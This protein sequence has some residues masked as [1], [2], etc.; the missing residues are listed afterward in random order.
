MFRRV[1]LRRGAR[2]PTAVAPR[3]VSS[4]TLLTGLLKCACCGASMT[5]A[6]GKGGRY[7]YYKCNTRIG[8]GIDYCESENLPMQKL[9]ALVLNSLADRVFTAA[10]VRLM[11]EA[12]AQQAKESG[13]EQQQQLATLKREL[14]AVTG[15]M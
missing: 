10:R 13:K 11:L 14:A 9:D 7:R 3:V 6:T 1:Q 15:G 4:P 8:K 12:L 2:A 5:L